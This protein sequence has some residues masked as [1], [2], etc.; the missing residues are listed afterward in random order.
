LSL[1]A[2]TGAVCSFVE[3]ALLFLPVW[4]L[5]S[6][7]PQSPSESRVFWLVAQRIGQFAPRQQAHLTRAF[8][9][10]WVL[11]ISS[12]ASWIWFVPG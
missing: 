4:Q 7:L 9:Q 2:S 12:R 5:G 10:A 3:C 1:A 11:R 6:A 8:A